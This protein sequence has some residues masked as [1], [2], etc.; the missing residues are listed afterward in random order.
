[1]NENN[2]QYYSSKEKPYLFEIKKEDIFPLYIW[3]HI[4]VLLA[5]Y[6]TQNNSLLPSKKNELVET[7]KNKMLNILLNQN[8]APESISNIQIFDNWKIYIRYNDKEWEE[9][10]LT[11]DLNNKEF[12]LWNEEELKLNKEKQNRHSVKILEESDVILSAMNKLFVQN[13]NEFFDELN[14]ND[15]LRSEKYW[16]NLVWMNLIELQNL[17]KKWIDEIKNY[18]RENLSTKV[19]ND[20]IKQEKLY[21]EMIMW[22]WDIYEWWAKLLKENTK[23]FTRL[24]QD[25]VQM[26]W[27][28][29]I[30]DYLK[31][32]H[33]KI[34]LNNYQSTT[35]EKSYNFLTE[36]LHR[37]V[38]EKLIKNNASDQDLLYFAKIVTWRGSNIDDNLRDQALANEALL[39]IMNREKGIIEKLN[40]SW[41]IEISDEKVIDKKPSK[42]V[43]ELKDNFYI[44]Y[45]KQLE[46]L[47]T[48]SNILIKSWYNDVLNIDEDNEYQ[49]LTFQ[50][51]TKIS[52]LY[53]VL[54]KLKE[55]KTLSEQTK[56]LDL[57]DNYNYSLQEFA[58]LFNLVAQDY[59][60][61]VTETIEESFWSNNPFWWEWFWFWK[62]ASDMELEWL[63]AEIFDIF[64]DINW[65]WLLDFSDTSIGYMKTWGKFAWVIAIAVAVPFI[66]VAWATAAAWWA[67]AVA[68]ATAAWTAWFWTAAGL[69]SMWIVAQWAAAWWAATLASMAIN[70]HWYDTMWEAAV[71]ISS[72]LIVWSATWAAGWVL[73]KKVWIES[74]SFF[75]KEWKKVAWT[76][77]IDLAF[78]W[79]VPEIA[80]QKYLINNNFHNEDLLTN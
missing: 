33:Q 10:K 1:M 54:E 51:K 34:D 58:R 3:I 64:Q 38:L 43:N 42:I 18:P 69:A 22:V 75:S 47:K 32:L 23:E 52:V 66:I 40:K 61:D 67:A 13:D 30:L 45:W 39:Y 65:N 5:E 26:S 29:E 68:A 44:S 14:K 7:F 19:T 49:D 25:I 31:E 60:D 56:Q 74:A 59:R 57:T 4:G 8:I 41:S 9:I 21:L 71:D 62:D 46:S 2:E 20:L 79:L 37:L 73:L 53:R 11:F 63:D 48:F 77:V 78:L 16:K 6:F 28:R 80:R 35:V 70:P 50:Q 15:R 17:F 24:T 27:N 76:F 72:D 36:S 55:W 12:F